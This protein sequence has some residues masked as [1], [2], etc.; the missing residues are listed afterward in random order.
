MPAETPNSG[1]EFSH[2]DLPVVGKRVLRLGV[3]GNYGLKTAD[4]EYAADQG[5]NFW[6]WSP[7]FKEVT[8]ALRRLLAADRERHV[9]AM[10]GMAYAKGGVRRGIDKGRRML[11]VDYLDVFQLGWLGRGSLLTRGIQDQLAAAR[12]EGLVRAAGTSIHDRVRAG[13]LARDSVLDSLMIRYNAAHPGAEQDIFPHLHHRN[14][15]LISYTATSW[16]QL[17][18]PQGIEMASPWPG[19]GEGPAVPPLTAPLCYRF[20]L[21]SP[22]V[23]VALTGPKDRAQFDENLACLDQGPLSDTEMAWVREYGQK[24]RGKRKIPFM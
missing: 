2:I 10:F 18:K 5:V 17:L 20:V 3:A 9:V 4:I 14:P 7:R 24:V 1:E 8:P 22:H 16:R 21:S 19:S 11:G 12:A 6:V 15:L 13:E 23:H